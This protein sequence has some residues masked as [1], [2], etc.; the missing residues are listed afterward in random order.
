MPEA[1][2]KP[3]PTHA[4]SSSVV[5]LMLGWM[6]Q[7][8]DSFLATQRILVDFATKKNANLLKNLREGIFESE[9]SPMA[10]LTELAVEA[11][12]NLTEAQKILLDLAQQENE[13]IMTGVKERVGS[14]MAVAVSERLR[15]A[16]NTFVDMQQDFLTTISKHVQQ[17]L[18]ATQAGKGPDVACLTDAARDALEGFVRAQKKFLDIVVLEEVKTKGGE[19]AKKKTELAKLAREAADAFID[20]QKKLL[21]LAGQQM[22]VNVQTATHAVDMVK[23]FRPLPMPEFTGEQVKHFIDAEKALIES[24]IKPANGAKPVAKSGG[25]KRPARRRPAGA[26]EAAQAGA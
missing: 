1:V 13:I 10:I 2:K 19:S 16:I 11:T 3:A 6:Q 21:D 20:T 8:M 15:R 24:I 22:N 17:R 18:E 14:T 7:G 23:S 12:A 4:R 25:A 9:H 5:T 26:A